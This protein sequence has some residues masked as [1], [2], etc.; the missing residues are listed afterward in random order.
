M[1]QI[2]V[3]TP[4]RA[5][6][7][8]LNRWLLYQ[9]LSSR[10][11]G[12]SG[13]YQSSGAY[14]FRDQLQ[15]VMA[16]LH[17]RPAEARHHILRA[18]GHQFEPGDVLHWWHPPSGRGVR[19]RISDDLLWL[20]FVTAHYVASTGDGSILSE[21]VPFLSGPALKPDEE[22][23]YDHYQPSGK[24]GTLFEHCVRAIHQASTE[25]RHG[26]PLMG[27]GDWNDGMN[28]VGIEGEGESVWLGWFLYATL[29]RFARVSRRIGQD[30]RAEEFERQAERLKGALEEHAWDGNW[31]LRA[32]YDDGSPLGSSRNLE[33]QIDAIAQSWSVLSGAGTDERQA[34]AMESVE[35]RLVRRA[36]QL[37]LL[38]TPP[39]DR[40]TRD[41][42]YVKGYLPGIR[43]N[44]GQYTHAALWTV[45]AYAELGRGSMAGS[46][47]ALLNPINH[48]KDP[49]AV[50]R[51]QV[52]PY[53]VAADVYSVAPHAG[54]G[55]W[56]W[57]TGSAGWMY[58]LGLEG[59]LGVQREG[60]ALRI[61]PRIPADWPAFRV[62]YRFGS[63]TYHIEVA[64]PDG[65]QQGV[66]RVT[67]DGRE[68]PEG[69]IPLEADAGEHRVEVEMG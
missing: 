12:R 22:E 59:I 49:G 44:G 39:F 63:A 1:G 23:R 52:E 20:P 9:N 17:A 55:G 51:Y 34:R 21:Q 13:F 64:N 54:R 58:R 37:I 7:V 31:Y 65:V 41:P 8:M 14:G 19:T 66:R 28:H 43:E 53:V 68:M 50:E 26:L 10:I 29:T 5:M 36:D 15:D 56:T 25:G 11:W 33:C 38:F 60:Q 62:D 42:G 69:L 35:E 18:A 47:Y 61:D 2:T 32:F 30:E 6:D 48:A 46:L 27:A 67:L 24:A 57:Y 4:D 45:W 40:T 16:V 3:D